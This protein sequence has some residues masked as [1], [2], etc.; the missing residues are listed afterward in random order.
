MTI[1]NVTF[2]NIA[3]LSYLHIE[4]LYNVTHGVGFVVSVHLF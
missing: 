3:D 4:N 1:K 2:A